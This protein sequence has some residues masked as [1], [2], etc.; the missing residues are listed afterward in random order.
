MAPQ[1]PRRGWF[2][3]F[4]SHAPCR[5]L[6]W[7]PAHGRPRVLVF[8]VSDVG[9]FAFYFANTN[10]NDWLGWEIPWRC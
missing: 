10:F 6:G 1:D 4:I 7:P 2:Y 9:G 8:E 5:E 3:S